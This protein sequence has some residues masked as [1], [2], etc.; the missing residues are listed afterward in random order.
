MIWNIR[1]IFIT[2][3]FIFINIIVK[4]NNLYFIN[5]TT[6]IFCVNIPTEALMVIFG[7]NIPTEVLTIIFAVSILP[8]KV[9]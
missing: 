1:P 7:V 5:A 3:S 2:Y 9:L 8:L 4:I 6:K